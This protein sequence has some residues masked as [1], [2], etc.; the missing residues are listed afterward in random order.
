LGVI[1]QCAAVKSNDLAT[2]PSFGGFLK[3]LAAGDPT[4][5]IGYLRKREEILSNFLPAILAGFAESGD[6]HIALSLVSQWIDQGRHLHAIARYLHYATNTPEELVIRV[7]KQAIMQKDAIAAIGIVAAIIERRLTSVVDSVFLPSIQMLTDLEDAR[8]VNGCWFAVSLP[9]F[10][11]GLSQGQSEIL[12]TNLILR[13]RVEHQDER[14]L[15]ALAAKYPRLVLQFFKRRIDRKEH[16]KAENQY[17]AIPY[18]MAELSKVLAKDAKLVIQTARGW[19]YKGDMLLSYTG[20]RLLQNIFPEFTRPCEAELLGL[21][22]GGA[23]DDI[24]F[25]L[26]LLRSYRGGTSLHE[27]CKALL[28]VFPEGDKRIGQIRAIVDSTGVV[29]GEFGMVEAYQRKKEEMRSWLSDP[30]PKVRAFAETHIRTLDGIIASE[31]RRA[32]TDRELRRRDWTE[33]DS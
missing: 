6:P 30:R 9:P 31:Q 15:C 7:G 14:L 25:V 4:I 22:W 29:M 1:E 12:L 8:W 13:E 5:V 18:H 16:R 11:A 33:E 21:V 17:E 32:E 28:E 23:E 2:F 10:L 26:S 24:D 3:Q 20:G 19:Y 27:V